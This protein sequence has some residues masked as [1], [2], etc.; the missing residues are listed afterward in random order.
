MVGTVGM[1]G[2]V[3]AGDAVGTTS[4]GLRRGRAGSPAPGS[5]ARA[6]ALLVA[7]TVLALSWPAAGQ[8]HTDLLGSTPRAGESVAL[9]TDR[10]VLQFSAD[11]VAEGSH[12]AVVD[13]TG[14]DVATDEAATLGD[15]VSVPVALV[16]P[17]RHAVTYRVL[18]ADGHVLVG[19]LDFT[20]RPAAS[21]PT[22]PAEPA[23]GPGGGASGDSTGGT[24]QDTGQEAGGVAGGQTAAPGA[25][26][27]PGVGAD[28][29][30]SPGWT[31]WAPWLVTAAAGVAVILVHRVQTARAAAGGRP[32]LR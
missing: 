11:L 13:P 17:G 3:G 30:A 26:A 4:A 18:A 9:T 29:P 23:R 8:A 27:L 5:L 31:L 12:V 22:G 14:T 15:T 28:E 32:H 19:S 16:R 20:V 1:V 21:A 7:G 24:G 2:M 6:V 25:G 10:V